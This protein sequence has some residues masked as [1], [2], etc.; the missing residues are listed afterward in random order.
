MIVYHLEAP[1]E[2]SWDGIGGL[3]VGVRRALSNLRWPH[4]QD[5][6]VIGAR[7]NAFL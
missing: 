1:L 7:L 5:G 4:G 3:G 6:Q 2:Q